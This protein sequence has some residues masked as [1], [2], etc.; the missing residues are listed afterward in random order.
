V[1][2]PA[3]LGRAVVIIIQITLE[4]LKHVINEGKVF[5]SQDFTSLLRPLATSAN[6]YHRSTVFLATAKPSEHKLAYL[7]S[8]V[9][10]YR[11]VG[12]IDPGDM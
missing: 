4:A 5:L 8:E 3:T 12:F 11:P 10:I 9:F 6:Q 1:I 2:A 7:G